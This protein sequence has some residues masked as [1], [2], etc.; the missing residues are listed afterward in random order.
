MSR[1]GT[2]RNI[3]IV[4]A[5]AAAVEL[6]PGGGRAADT[7]GAVL[8]VGF[9]TGVVYLGL[10][11]YREHRITLHSLGTRHR[12]MLYGALALIMAGI[13]ARG[14]MWETG[15]GEFLWFLA[16]GLA[17]YLLFAVYRFWRAY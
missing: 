16:I 2:V 10:M 1:V 13:V 3:V 14:R 9:C 17:V 7:F 11:L 4:L 12:G 5:I 8:L 6:L 15:L